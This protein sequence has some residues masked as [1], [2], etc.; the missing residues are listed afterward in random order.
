MGMRC[1]R[2]PAQVGASS[3]PDIIV[4]DFQDSC[5]VAYANIPVPCSEKSC[6]IIYPKY[7]SRECN[8]YEDR[9]IVV[10]S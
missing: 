7:T 10:D 1:L 2:A 5:I 9:N 4:P 3:F 6:G 8:P